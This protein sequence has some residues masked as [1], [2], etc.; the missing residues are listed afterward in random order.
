MGQGISFGDCYEIHD[1]DSDGPYNLDDE[2]TLSVIPTPGH[3]MDSVSLIVKDARE[4][5]I[6]VESFS[7]ITMGALKVKMCF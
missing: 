1:F 7:F 6:D 5:A 3:T 2:G 4:D